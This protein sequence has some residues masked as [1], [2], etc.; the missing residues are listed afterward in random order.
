M[1]SDT[2]PHE[3]L[4]LNLFLARAGVASRRKSAELIAAGRVTVNGTVME[5]PGYRVAATDAVSLDGNPIG[6]TPAEHCYILL[7]KP[8]GYECSRPNLHATRTIY[9]LVEIPGRRLFSVG[10][11]DKNSEGMLLLTDDGDFANALT[12]PSREIEKHYLIQT[13]NP[14]KPT[15]IRRMMNGLEDDGEFLKASGVYPEEPPFVW[16][17][18]LTEG[19]KREVRRLI[20]R[21][22]NETRRLRRIAIG[23]LTLGD[24]PEGSW[25]ELSPEELESLFT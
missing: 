17:I 16:R 8:A 25:R 22:R 21:C 3:N 12:H 18:V 9:D 20:K 7:N 13:R 2:N 5:R 11:L 19:K 4:P 15:D 6:D 14:L 1:M 24:L 23:G 10:R